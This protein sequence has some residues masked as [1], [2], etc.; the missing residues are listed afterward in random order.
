MTINEIIN[1]VD[2]LKPNGFPAVL[3]VKWLS[4][5]DGQI[6]KE[7]FETHE[8]NPFNRRHH[9]HHEKFEGYSDNT[10]MSQVLLVPDP[11]DENI[12]SFYLQACIDRENGETNKYNQ[13]ITLFN[14]AY[15]QFQND[16]NRKHM[17]IHRGRRFL[18]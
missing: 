6:Y 15:L 17:P 3:K 7:V 10:P 18:F 2:K 13:T 11:F 4:K 12:Y 9:H 8:D 14:N 5:L 1:L 16:Y